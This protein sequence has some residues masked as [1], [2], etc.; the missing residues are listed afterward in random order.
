MDSMIA[1]PNSTATPD[2]RFSVAPMMAWTTSSQ[3]YFARLISQRALL[4]TEMLT[5]GAVIHGDRNKLLYF[6]AAEHPVALQLGGSHP[7]DMSEAA[8]IGEAFGYDEININ[9]GCPSDR[10]QNGRFGACLM[11]E[12]GLVAECVSA[13][14]AAVS[15][16]VTVKTR[17]GIDNQDDYSALYHFVKTLA[18]AGCE[19]FIVHARKAWLAGL[20]PKENREKPPLKYESV[21]RLKQEF[22]QLEI[23]INGGIE[24]LEQAQSHMPHVDGVMLGRA[25][26]K[27]P[28][29]LAEVDKLFYN[30]TRPARSRHQVVEDLL[31]YID[32]RLHA[33]D[34]LPTITRHILGLFHAQP[35]GRRWRQ[36]LSQNAHKKGAGCEVVRAALAHIPQQSLSEVA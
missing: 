8:R 31:P 23:L 2:R 18:A 15:I 7:G 11:A 32:E 26:Y 34:A 30:D 25:A 1:A 3:R 36:M 24:N 16:P 14:Q 10:V 29:L 35:G 27:N 22:P 33:G 19:T 13:M 5:S 21:Y 12:P 4:Y 9:I 20:S 28:Y 17:I 6:D